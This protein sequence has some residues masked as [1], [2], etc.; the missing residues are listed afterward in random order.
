MAPVPVSNVQTHQDAATNDINRPET[1]ARSPIQRPEPQISSKLD[2]PGFEL[3]E[4]Y[5]EGGFH[6]VHVDDVLNGRYEVVNK[7]GDGGFGIVWLCLDLDTLIWRAVKVLAAC[8]SSEDC[9][10]LRFWNALKGVDQTVL[11]PPL[12]HFWVV[13]PNGRHLCFVVPVLGPPIEGI[14]EGSNAKLI[15]KNC[16]RAA[17]AMHILH[18]NGICHGDFRQA[19]ILHE[20]KDFDDISREEM[21]DVIGFARMVPFKS[22]T[23]AEPS[24]RTPRFEVHRLHESVFRAYIMPGEVAVVDLDEAFEAANPPNQ[25]TGIPLRYQ[26]PEVLLGLSLSTAS[27]IWAL[28][29]AILHLHGAEGFAPWTY[30]WTFEHEQE[31]IQNMERHLGALPERYQAL[32][33]EVY[34]GLRH[35]NKETPTEGFDPTGKAMWCWGNRIQSKMREW[36]KVRIAR[37]GYKHPLESQIADV[38][39]MSE[40]DLLSLAD[41]LR[42]M[43]TLDAERRIN[44]RE[45]L[46]HR[47]LGSTQNQEVSPVSDI[48]SSPFRSYIS[49]QQRSYRASQPNPPRPVLSTVLEGSTAEAEQPEETRLQRNQLKVPE[50]GVSESEVP[51]PILEPSKPEPLQSLVQEPESVSSEAPKAGPIQ[52]QP[53]QQ[54]DSETT[55]PTPSLTK[56]RSQLDRRDISF[57]FLGVF[58]TLWIWAAVTVALKHSASVLPL[59][60]DMNV[61]NLTVYVLPQPYVT[62]TIAPL[63]SN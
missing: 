56:T 36:R 26:A 4:M 33:D 47:W 45:V 17:E 3:V 7:L 39:S 44:I 48:P 25:R 43:F 31:T 23:G 5:C 52:S 35:P 55:T 42:N 24:I 32:Y 22:I 28:A 58:F 16:L 15:K 29:S 34:G 53:S 49:S 46:N 6:P 30:P 8:M 11:A 14:L 51:V 13:G 54:I 59:L 18:S 20:L 1:E 63:S 50:L 38:M 62:A 10:E 57:M 9:A 40:S 41:L 27:D 21:M 61:W 37:T 2:Y 12:E 19:N 60:P